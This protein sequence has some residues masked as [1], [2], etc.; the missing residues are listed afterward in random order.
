[1]N[2]T[3]VMKDL[4]NK[5]LGNTEEGSR[6]KQQNIERPPMFMDGQN[7]LSNVQPT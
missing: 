4:Q 5:N 6:E 1:M 7:I 2:P 3:K